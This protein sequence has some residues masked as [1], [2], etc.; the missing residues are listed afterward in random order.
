APRVHLLRFHGVLAP[1]A[2]WRS[3][4]IPRPTAAAREEP[5]ARVRRSGPRALAGSRPA[6][7]GGLSWS[8]LLKRGF[9]IA[10]RV[11]PRCGGRR[12]IVA[13]LT[14][15]QRLRRLLERLGLGAPAAVPGPSR[16]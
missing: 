16:S 6:C 8:A 12:N 11:C 9:A 10:V 15:G 5:D 13:V 14:A 2:A 4:S 3:P 7:S 1:H